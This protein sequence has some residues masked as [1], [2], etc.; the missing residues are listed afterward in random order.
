MSTPIRVLIVE[1]READAE[2]M[3]HE[4]QQAGYNADWQRVETEPD[5]LAGLKTNPDLILADWSLP[6]FNGLRALQLANERGQ[7]IPFIIVSGVIG[8]EAAVESMRLG[9]ADYLM[10]DRLGRLGQAVCHALE[11]KQLRAERKRADKALKDSEQRFRDIADNAHEFIW[12]IDPQG[13]W[14]YISQVAEKILGYTSEEFLQKYFYDFFM[15]EDRE[16]VK[17]AVFAAFAAKQSFRG[18]INRSVHKNGQ[19]VWLSSS[20]L[21]L[22][23]DNG[24]LLGYRGA[25]LDITER[26]QAE[27]ALRDSEA[28]Y[29]TLVE[30]LPQIIFMKDREFKYQSVNENYARNLGVP[31]ADIVG[32][33]DYELYPKERAD[34]YRAVDLSIMETGQTK[35]LEEKH[36]QE[37]RETW[38]HSIKAPVRDEN[39][40]I[41]AI[42]GVFWDITESK[43]AEM[44]LHKQL[45]EL[46]LWRQSTLGRETRILDLKG[47][48]NELLVMAG[49]PLR[50][51]SAETENQ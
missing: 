38:A 29:R 13:R 30:N 44:R 49:Q 17:T 42:L 23:D 32:K 46:R 39:G 34:K 26:K 14:T 31:V 25:N 21:P 9:V 19:T 11:D 20:A 7:D 28:K 15:P 4:L 16:A 48:V 37:G 43:L 45:D 5:F 41:V 1:D 50:Y 12:E 51:P 3:L 24:N 10:K 36:M 27:D 40:E 8:E 18:F 2:L 33:T 47:E 6:Q 22:L 35:E